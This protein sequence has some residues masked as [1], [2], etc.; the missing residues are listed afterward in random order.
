MYL[1]YKFTRSVAGK[2]KHLYVLFNKET[3]DIYFDFFDSRK[4]LEIDKEY[5]ANF[6]LNAKVIEH[7]N[8]YLRDKKK[9]KYVHW[10]V[11]NKLLGGRYKIGRWEL[12]DWTMDII[13][14]LDPNIDVM[15]SIKAIPFIYASRVLN[16]E[17]IN[18]TT[19][20]EYLTSK[21]VLEYDEARPI[22]VQKQWF[23]ST[24]KPYITQFGIHKINEMLLR[25]K[26]EKLPHK[27]SVKHEVKESAYDK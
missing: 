8:P 16:F 14:F 3:K 17:Y 25:D 9:H 7:K 26:Y 12:F 20:K 11:F 13:Y 4:L 22:F 5:Y 18:R 10:T 27:K 23:T 21:G 6:E 15:Q 2:E 19:L 24:Y 1:D